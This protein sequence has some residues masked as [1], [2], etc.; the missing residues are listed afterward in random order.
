MTSAD[1]NFNL[2]TRGKRPSFFEADETDALMTAL[3]ETM[4]QLWATRNQVTVLQKILIEKG[5]LSKEELEKFVLSDSEKVEEHKVMQA[6]FSDAFRAMGSATQSLESRQRD[7]DRLQD[8][9]D[10]NG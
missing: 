2:N 9:V 6:F 4:S 3:L 1:Q 7:I 8:E 5:L 10:D